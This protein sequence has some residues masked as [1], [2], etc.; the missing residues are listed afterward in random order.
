MDEEEQLAFFLEWDDPQSGLK[1]GYIMHYHGDNTV[2]LVERKTRK[3]FLKR[4]RIPTV[5]LDDLYVG[6]SVTV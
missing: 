5:N 2:E 1:K 4:I 3:I 6:S